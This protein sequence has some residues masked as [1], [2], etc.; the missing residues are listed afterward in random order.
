[1]FLV[2]QIYWDYLL[3]FFISVK[4]M[5]SI[6]RKSPDKTSQANRTE[7]VCSSVGNVS[8]DPTKNNKVRTTK[9]TVFRTKHVQIKNFICTLYHSR[10][11]LILTYSMMAIKHSRHTGLQK[12]PALGRRFLY[13]ELEPKI[14]KVPN[15]DTS[16]I[17]KH[18][19]DSCNF[20]ELLKGQ[21]LNHSHRYYSGCRSNN[22]H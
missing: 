11:S 18:R 3:I 20:Q 4:S 17:P 1:M 2:A 15:K 6:M 21:F 7:L 10:V 22:K 5:A 8:R 14:L 16:Y 19:W 12:P 13:L 9:A